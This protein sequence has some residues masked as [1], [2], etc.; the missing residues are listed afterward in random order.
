MLYLCFLNL[1]VLPLGVRGD[2]WMINLCIGLAF[3]LLALADY[4]ASATR[5]G[6]VRLSAVLVA[7]LPL[8]G[9]IIPRIQGIQ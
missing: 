4:R 1:A 2:F 9:V 5:V 6:W 7:L 8:L 3:G